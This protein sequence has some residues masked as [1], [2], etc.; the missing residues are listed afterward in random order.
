MKLFPI[1][2]KPFLLLCLCARAAP[3]AFDYRPAC[4]R[5]LALASAFAAV[6]GE[7]TQSL[8][9]PASL[10]D[11]P[12]WRLCASTVRP[13]G[14]Q[15]LQTHSASLALTSKRWAF[16]ATGQ[17]FGENG[18]REETLALSLARIVSD[19]I[20]LGMTLRQADLRIHGYGQS[21]SAVFDLGLWTRP[22]PAVA[23]GF[24]VN[25]A[26]AATIGRC[27][28][29]LPQ[30]RRWGLLL[31]LSPFLH[32]STE[33]SKDIRYPADFACGIEAFLHPTLCLRAGIGN[34]P[35]RVA[36]GTGIFIGSLRLDYA[37]E[38]HAELGTTHQLSAVL[39]INSP[40]K[41]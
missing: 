21:R 1:R 2:I 28:E 8:T 38:I 17:R 5:N 35:G 34:E 25:N 27:R 18:Y 10:P 14:L 6:K 32:I 20:T 7:P 11:N 37:A 30:I 29:P 23:F 33:L 4:A 9:N 16:A 39:L 41:P 22:H 15:A 40:A 26:G 24:A 19:K 31:A 3:A 13:Y 36:A 12:G